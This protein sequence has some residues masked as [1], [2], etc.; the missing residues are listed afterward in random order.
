[1]KDVP[2]KRPLIPP[3]DK[4]QGG[5]TL[6]PGDLSEKEELI[7]VLAGQSLVGAFIYHRGRIVY[8]NEA[9]ARII[10][11][12]IDET[13]DADFGGLQ[14][15]I[16]PDDLP[17][18]TEQAERKER[19]DGEAISRY[20][21]RVITK[22]GEVRWVEV[23][24][25]SFTYCGTSA[26]YGLV[27]EMTDGKH[28]EKALRESEGRYRLLA[29][30]AT[31]VI[32]TTDMDLRFTYMS[33]SVVRVTGYDVRQAEARTLAETLTPASFELARK[34]FE[35]ELALERSGKADPSR[36][37][38]L[39]LEVCREDSSTVWMEVRMSFLRDQAG[40]P[41]GVL[42]VAR[43]ISD[44]KTA[45]EELLRARKLESLGILAG[46][47]AHDFNNLLGAILA[48]VSLARKDAGA[49]AKTLE[50]LAEARKAA[51]RA[52]GLTKQLLTFSKGGQPVRRLAS[53]SGL[54]RDSASFAL[55]RSGIRCIFDVQR[56][57][58]HAEIDEGQMYQVFN[59][60]IVNASQAMGEGG[61]ITVEAVNTAIEPGNPLRL[62]AGNYVRVS[63]T[64]QGEGISSDNISR[65]F[66]PYFSTKESGVGLGLAVAHAI[67]RKHDG[68]I[69]VESEPGVGA[70][71]R[72]YLPA[73]DKPLPAA[74]DKAASARRRGG[75]ILLMEDE[76]V[77]RE[78]AAEVLKDLGYEVA[79]ATDGAEAVKTY[80]DAIR[81]GTPFDLIIL[82]LTV[83]GKLGGKEA[84]EKLL[85]TDPNV[86]AV[87]SSGYSADPIMAEYKHHGFTA[88]LAKPYDMDEMAAVIQEAMGPAT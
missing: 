6:G 27:I 58:Y 17:F 21:Y 23:F 65:I 12:S 62:H 76:D 82:D 20:S 2:E 74:P 22:S 11:Y 32:W 42:G 18:V 47:I 49:G 60:L 53:I 71:F 4:V 55:Q 38:T 1:M 85:E 31:D 59:N 46:G 40:L 8:I 34:T 25:Q 26:I 45:E 29:E 30:N 84:M 56:D 66:D 28:A 57:L 33:P 83:P 9:A 63:I 24:S 52:R 68:H 41:V 79:V 54:L 43:D 67:V 15:F 48:N 51:L 80:R 37:R 50:R 73:F 75:R 7:R 13:L 88:V 36:S 61:T 16:H 14:R 39:E 86:R 35:E 64:D 72:I 19:R 10:G 3:L 44:R 5:P 78:A 70:T 81:S 69:S 77:M 87:A